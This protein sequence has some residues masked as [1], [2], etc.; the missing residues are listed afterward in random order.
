MAAAKCFSGVAAA[1]PSSSDFAVR[2]SFSREAFSDGGPPISAIGCSASPRY[3]ARTRWI[4]GSQPISFRPGSQAQG[5]ALDVPRREA[6]SPTLAHLAS[7]SCQGS[8]GGGFPQESGAGRIEEAPRDSCADGVRSQPAQ[9]VARATHSVAQRRAP[10]KRTVDEVE[11]L[12]V[13]AGQEAMRAAV[14]AAC[15]DAERQAHSCPHGASARLQSVGRD[16]RPIQASFGRVRLQLRRLRCED[17]GRRIRPAEPF[18]VSLAG[19]NVTSR[20][21]AACVLAGSSWPYQAAATV[22]RDLCGAAISAEWVR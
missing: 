1:R 5:G 9:E 19:G 14:Q 17:C 12:I 6:A 7:Q 16:A 20:L 11:P 21:R 22:L 3:A 15:R 8:G 13:A 2:C 10:G 18:L 4:R